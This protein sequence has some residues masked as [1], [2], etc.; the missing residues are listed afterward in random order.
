MPAYTILIMKR[1]ETDRRPLTLHISTQLF[2]SLL[3]LAVALPIGGFLVS[4]GVIAP[5]WLK[6]DFNSMRHQV[7]KAEEMRK[8]YTAF[9]AEYEQMKDQLDTERKQRAEAEAKNTMA[10]TARSE[11]TAKLTQL[12]GEVLTLRQSVATYEQL[13]KPKLERELVQCVN[14]DAGYKDGKVTYSLNLA[15]TSAGVSLPAKLTAR[16]S[17]IVGDNALVMQNAG[18]RATRNVTLETGKSLAIKGDFAQEIPTDTTRL[19]DIK[20]FDGG[21]NKPVGYCWKTF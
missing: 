17:V 19:I 8:E 18:N 4:A 12:E 3:V 16:V 15:K 5:A 10:E 20:V 6:L 11:A 2:W 14:L 13:L 9:K 21:G 1:N 7:Q